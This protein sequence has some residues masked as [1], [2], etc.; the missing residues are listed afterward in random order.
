MTLENIRD[1]AAER[2]DA[3]LAFIERGIAE[4]TW[5]PGDKLPTERELE[6]MFGLSRN[7]LRKTLKPLEDSGRIV[8]HVGRG[9]FVGTTKPASAPEGESLLRRIVGAS[10]A[11]VMEVRLMLEPH[12]AELAAGRANAEDLRLL[13]ECLAR[14]EAAGDVPEFEHWDGRLHVTI[15]GATKN[16][17]LMD[18]YEA[19]N[20]VRRQAEWGKLKARTVTTERRKVYME[21]HRRIVTALRD[22]DPD[23]A[24]R[25][26]REHLEVVRANLLGG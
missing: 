8:R 9:S 4:G 3:V 17:L 19:I 7:T 26:L 16:G 18:L 23:E 13:E 6:R 11:E 21:Q 22:R 24:R 15:V 25:S 2:V 10:P 14:S 1:R 20:D 5:Q 12:A